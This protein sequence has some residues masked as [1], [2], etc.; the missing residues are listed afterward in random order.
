MVEGEFPD[1]DD[2]SMMISPRRTVLDALLVD[3]ARGA[4]A[5]AREG[6]SL[7]ELTSERDRVTGV[8]LQEKR[9]AGSMIESA[10]FVVGADGSIQ[11]S[12]GSSAQR[13]G[14][15][16][17]RSPSRST[18]T[19]TGCPSRVARSTREMDTQPAHG[20]PMTASP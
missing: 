17:L 15:R 12:R 6:C 16:F 18:R 14:V 19:G 4:G 8:R 5:E 10:A 1:H 13:S 11:G 2:V 3:A 7:V 20:R 9:T